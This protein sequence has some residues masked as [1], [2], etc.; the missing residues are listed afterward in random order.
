MMLLREDQISLQ[1]INRCISL[2]V[3][4][5]WYNLE[6]EFWAKIL[7]ERLC[8]QSGGREKLLLSEI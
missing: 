1:P 2:F 6:L 3:L 4:F 7:Q 5:C 8:G